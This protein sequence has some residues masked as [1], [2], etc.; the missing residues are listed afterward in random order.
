MFAKKKKVPTISLKI[1][2]SVWQTRDSEKITYVG[3][4]TFVIFHV[5]T[6]ELLKD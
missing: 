6:T 4:G 5:K 2:E 3:V 1:P